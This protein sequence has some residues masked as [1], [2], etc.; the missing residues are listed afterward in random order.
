MKHHRISYMQNLSLNP[1][2][3]HLR[4]LLRAGLKYYQIIRLEIVFF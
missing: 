4:A 1:V 2:G 3:T